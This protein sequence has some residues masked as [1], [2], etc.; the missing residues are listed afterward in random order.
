MAVKPENDN[1]PTLNVNVKKIAEIYLH[2]PI[3]LGP[4]VHTDLTY[5]KLYFF[6]ITTNNEEINIEAA[7]PQ[8]MSV[9][10]RHTQ[11]PLV[12]DHLLLLE[13]MMR[14]FLDQSLI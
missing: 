7:S 6:F 1:L 8:H 4:V 3:L 2:F 5:K 10:N 14:S 11:K 13:R 12:F 9:S